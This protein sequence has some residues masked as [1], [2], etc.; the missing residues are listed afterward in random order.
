MGKVLKLKEA[1]N[2]IWETV[3]ITEEQNA[4]GELPY[5]FIVG[6][7]ISAPEI[8]PAQGIVNHC[9][10]KVKELYRDENERNEIFEKSKGLN[11]NSAKYYSYWF[12]QAYKNKI[13]RQQ[14]L[15][16]IIGKARIST[17]NL[18]L[19]QILN[20]KKVATTVI[21][22]NFDNQL[23]KSLNLLGN[24]DVFSANNALDN[25]ALSRNSSNVQIMHV[26]GTYEFYDC[27]NLEHEITRVA[28][29][30]GIRSTAGTIEEFLKNQ[31]PIVIGYS[32]WEDDVIMSK[33]Y[34]RLAYAPLP[35][36][37]IWFCYSQRDY[38]NL[39]DW[40]KWS[41]DVLFVLPEME[42]GE[43]KVIDQNE[44]PCFLP[45]EDVMAALI[46]KFEFE[47]PKLF[48]NPIQYYIELIDGFFPENVDIFPVKAWKRR[49][50]HIEMHLEDIEKK[51]IDLDAASARKDVIEITRILNT[52]D[53][54]FISKDD[55]EH[56]ING[57]MLPSLS[58]KN[59]IENEQDVCAFVEKML[60]LLQKRKTDIECEKLK[61][62]LLKIID[63]LSVYK[64][65]GKKENLV[66]LYNAI[67]EICRNCEEYLEI[68]LITL[69]MKSDVSNQEEQTMLRG[70]IIEKGIEKIDD[71]RIGRLLIIAIGKQALAQENITEEQLEI[72]RRVLLMHEKNRNILEV[73]YRELLE[74]YEE[75][76]SMKTDISEII[77]EIMHKEVSEKVLFH[78]RCIHCQ[79]QEG[80]QEKVNI[81]INAIADY[82]IEIINSCGECL[83]YAFLLKI[84]IVGTIK[85]EKSVEQRYIDLAI[86]LCYREEGCW[87][88]SKIIM[89]S[90]DIY[91]DSID[92]QFEKR[93]LCKKAIDICERSKL[94]VD[95][96][97]FCN[98]YMH[99]IEK[100]DR[101]MFL[102]T[103]IRYQR[104]IET[105]DSVSDA[106]GEY[107][108][109]NKE[110]CKDILLEA[111][112]IFDE[113][114]DE[115]YNPALVN[116]CFMARRG[117][118]PGINIS[119]IEVLNKVTW[120]G[121]DAF[122]NINKALVYVDEGRWED[123][124]QEIKK[125]DSSIPK[126]IEWW[127]QEQVVGDT[128]KN[129]VL[130]LLTVEN[131]I[132]EGIDIIKS[133]EFWKACNDIKNLPDEIKKE[134]LDLQNKYS[135]GE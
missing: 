81:A 94:Y 61:K 17:S 13:H 19:A 102:A 130:L 98:T 33:I 6:A 37:L 74:L 26:H 121:E 84:I 57:I 54:N 90:L 14:Y 27:C 9:Q 20:S 131:K 51:I 25:I 8:L 135:V 86:K 3:K 23:L 101:E 134:L 78:A 123:A 133:I 22:P 50:N 56:I 4:N 118:I 63:F 59:R 105:R 32:G 18:L 95:W 52:I 99:A 7:G 79:K 87:M 49:L 15:K 1:V 83:D 115:K 89:D 107:V 113:L 46:S 104:Y 119:V 103:N 5:L 39:P 116:V 44:K 120:M 88:V 108:K 35:Y 34:E 117:E 2:L 41:D 11:V 31:A 72:M 62:Y 12:G 112:D 55:L 125:I 47:A 82:D 28:S 30:T 126:A 92:S 75:N 60:E 97:Y 10:E 71:D 93:E 66:K 100:Q 58:N 16:H 132:P 128:E 29:E 77:D 80:I 45:A 68:E 122:L 106:V 129:I 24:Y 111:S 85:L 91:V 127:S 38:E 21:T 64:R 76:I 73:Y 40:L 65:K 69:G 70:F 36:N 48:S 96:T 53:C 110:K 43:E 114:F 109:G 42:N 124:R 67:L